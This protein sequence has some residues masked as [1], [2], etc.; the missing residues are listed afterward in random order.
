MDD[1]ARVV[2]ADGLN[3]PQASRLP[4]TM[5]VRKGKG[6]HGANH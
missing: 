1:E 3:H 6:P 4:G 5:E 2:R